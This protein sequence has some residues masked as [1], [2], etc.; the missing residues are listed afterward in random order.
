MNRTWRAMLA[1][2]GVAAALV[3][4]TAGPAMAADADD[5]TVG[6][7]ASLAAIQRAGAEA[8]DRRIDSLNVA[9]ARVE[10]NDALTDDNRAAILNTLTTD[11]TA[12][13]DL[14]AQIAADT[15]IADAAADYRA[16]FTDY[17]VYAVALPQSL[18]AASADALTGSILPRLQTVHDNLEARLA[19]GDPNPDL[20]ALLGEMAQKIQ[21]AEAGAATIAADA[22]AVTPA[23]WNA[24]HTVLADIRADLRDA[25]QDAR[26]AARDARQIA[27]GL[28]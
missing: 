3:V 15:T 18:Y 25:T 12:M 9:I 8:T 23:D 5:P 20:E 2:A 28:R 17:R 26:D 7:G 24:D 22:L 13:N 10:G 1:S 27:Q 19:A 4:A 21:D 11:L 14:A 6:P 16:I